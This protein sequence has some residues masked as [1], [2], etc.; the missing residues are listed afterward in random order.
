MRTFNGTLFLEDAIRFAPDSSG[1][2]Y[3]DKSGT[4]VHIPMRLLVR[5]YEG[6]KH[7]MELREVDWDEFCSSL[8]DEKEP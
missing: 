3:T 6:V 8:F 4:D 7:H 1:V 2:K 5:L